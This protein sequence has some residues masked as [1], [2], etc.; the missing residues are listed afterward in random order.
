M[1]LEDPLIE[2]GVTR[3]LDTRGTALAA[4]GY[5]ARSGW[6]TSSTYG[7]SSWLGHSTTLSGQDRKSVV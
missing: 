4:A 7:G 5:R 2:P 6:L 1:A 3:T